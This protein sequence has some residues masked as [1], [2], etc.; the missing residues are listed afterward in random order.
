MLYRPSQVG[1]PQME[2][3]ANQREAGIR[4]DGP[5]LYEVFE[6]SDLARFSKPQIP[7]AP[8]PIEAIT[9]K[10]LAKKVRLFLAGAGKNEMTK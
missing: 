1:F 2:S 6:E 3:L 8:L 9:D 4:D 5:C 10:C 7:L